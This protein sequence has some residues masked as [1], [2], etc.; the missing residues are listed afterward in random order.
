MTPADF[1]LK[2]TNLILP[3]PKDCVTILSGFTALGGENA[4]RYEV[5]SGTGFIRFDALHPYFQCEL[6][7][8]EVRGWM[9]L[10]HLGQLVDRAELI[11]GAITAAVETKGA[12][13][14]SDLTLH[15]VSNAGEPI[16]GVKIGAMFL[17]DE[18]GLG[19][20][21]RL[22]CTL[23][24]TFMAIG[25]DSDA[26][27]CPC[28][29]WRT[30]NP[31]IG[32]ARDT[33]VADLW[34]A[35]E[36]QKMR[37]NFLE[38][39]YTE[40]CREDVCLVLRGVWK[41]DLYHPHEV[42]AVNEASTRLDY[43]PSLLQHD[44]DRG[45][46]LECT[47]C[48]DFKILPDQS[49]IDQAVADIRQAVALGTLDSISFSGAGEVLI[50]GKIVKLIESD[51]FSN[52]GISLYFTTNLT[53]FTAKLWERIKH[54]SIADVTVS[55]DG[56]SSEIYDKIRI[57]ALWE[58]VSENMRFLAELARAGRIGRINWNYTVQRANIAD[59]GKA[60]QL[61][62]T[63][64]FASIRLIGQVGALERTD[65]N[66]F[67]DFDRSALDALYAELEG[68]QAFGDPRVKFDEL[69]MR[70]RFYL[71]RA[72]RLSLARYFWD[73]ANLYGSNRVEACLPVLL[74]LWRDEKLGI[75][76]RADC[77]ADHFAPFITQLVD[78]L[79]SS[80]SLRQRASMWLGRSPTPYAVPDEMLNWL[81]N[82]A[83]E[84]ENCR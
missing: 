12:P 38:G 14:G 61:S 37:A 41:D 77:V 45:C 62:R 31:L 36:A 78:D 59:V 34:N 21:K 9:E 40:T 56:C 26:T 23:P 1:R 68:V 42:R 54:N 30:G 16:A 27:L 67:E 32:N 17:S 25:S 3:E 63:L 33:S 15:F 81:Q 69:G 44:I 19:L 22:R 5:E 84:V 11:E 76:Q 57:G 47:M 74:G 70:D 75:V 35:P 66:M 64:G 51:L 83:A 72:H 43:G 82:L 53:H 39:N 18:W 13:L 20:R 55:A 50:M 10:R 4:G 65:G 24:F 29:T 8:P 58:N 7:F 49:N 28:G 48:R 60:I 2:P 46:N 79:G 73:R 80:I 52:K 71:T 6:N